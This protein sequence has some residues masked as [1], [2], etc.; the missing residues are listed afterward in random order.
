MLDL[1]EGMFPV[2]TTAYF[3]CPERRTELAFINCIHNIVLLT[4]SQQWPYCVGV[5]RIEGG[6]VWL[7][8]TTT[9]RT[10]HV[11]GC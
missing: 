11:L 9:P 5:S 3:G 10:M 1:M 2:K 7:I 8:T 6:Y 4:V